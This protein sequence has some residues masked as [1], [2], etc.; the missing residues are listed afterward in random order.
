MSD[1]EFEYYTDFKLV[2]PVND[3]EAARDYLIKD[4]MTKYL[5]CSF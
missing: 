5:I 1:L 2:C 4:D 3:F